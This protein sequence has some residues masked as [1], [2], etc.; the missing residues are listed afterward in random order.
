MSLSSDINL[1]FFQ[2]FLYLE[3]RNPNRG[4]S[5]IFFYLG[6]LDSGLGICLKKILFDVFARHKQ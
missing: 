5:F 2:L 3:S 6:L 4:E 1:N